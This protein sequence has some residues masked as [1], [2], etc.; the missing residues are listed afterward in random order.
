[1]VHRDSLRGCERWEEK[2][3]IVAD[4]GNKSCK[5]LR[6]AMKGKLEGINNECA[7]LRFVSGQLHGLFFDAHFLYLYSIH[8]SC[9]L[10]TRFNQLPLHFTLDILAYHKSQHNLYMEG[11]GQE[12]HI[13]FKSLFNRLPIFWKKNEQ[14][15]CLSTVLSW[16]IRTFLIWSCF[17]I[18][19]RHFVVSYRSLG[20]EISLRFLSL[21]QISC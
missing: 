21:E 8:S 17:D 16:R 3:T 9:T 14:V 13:R 10:C 18:Q 12:L 11:W 6:L 7:E 15:L 20:Y 5:M 1:M 19:T 4:E 2:V